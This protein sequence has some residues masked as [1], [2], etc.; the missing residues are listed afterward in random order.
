[1]F[2][3]HLSLELKP[4]PAEDHLTM[5]THNH[6]IDQIKDE[7]PDHAD[8]V[9]E[10]VVASIGFQPLPG[11]GE[12]NST[13]IGG[14][15]D[16]SPD[17]EWPIR[18]A[19]DVDKLVA[20]GGPNHAEHLKK[21]IS[22]DLPYNFIAQID[23]TEAHA[24]GAVAADLPSKGRLL[25]FY[26]YA[27]GPWNNGEEGTRVIWDR[28]PERETVRR[29]IPLALLKLAEQEEVEYRAIMA[30]LMDEF[31]DMDDNPFQT[32]Y[33][34]P[35]QPKRLVEFWSSP[36]ALA[37]EID[38][39]PALKSA[40]FSEEEDDEDFYD[41]YMEFEQDGLP[42]GQLEFGYHRHKLL[43]L[44]DPEQSD[45]RYDAV[46][47]DITG[48]QFLKFEDGQAFFNAHGYRAVEWRLLLQIDMAEYLQTRS[49]GTVYF[50]I[51]NDDLR[52]RNFNNVFAVYQ[53]T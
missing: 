9:I 43:G 7:F 19:G 29:D 2:T 53:Q 31:P 24:L 49:E 12:L 46:V 47:F 48:E 5:T 11:E 42:G 41:S 13:R 36:N 37:H 51:R 26:D 20:L 34:G 33:W 28:G 3:Y 18:P 52:N 23:L 35:S 22:Q 6:L 27:I 8:L 50:L 21:H 16:L 25:F 15:P 30:K 38:E 17:I 1:M 4:E 45:P 39:K 32:K 44:P 40:L 14:T 10:A